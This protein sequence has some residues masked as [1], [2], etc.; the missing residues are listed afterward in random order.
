MSALTDV[1]ELMQPGATRGPDENW[2]A[3]GSCTRIDFDAFFPENGASSQFQKRVCGRCP[4]QIICLGR[5]LEL[6]NNPEN[7]A[8][9]I[10]G[11]L[12]PTERRAL[13]ALERHRAIAA[14]KDLRRAAS[15]EA[16]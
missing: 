12:D 9:G 13:T 2:M 10:W 11:G 3:Q 5:A 15:R 16:A 6:E 1:L 7:A 4:V 14:A 8:H